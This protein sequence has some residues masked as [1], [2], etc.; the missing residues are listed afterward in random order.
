MRSKC[1]VTGILVGFLFSAFV[2]QAQECTLSKKLD[3]R[4]WLD[5]ISEVQSVCHVRFFYDEET[6]PE[7]TIQIDNDNQS[8]SEVLNRNL[9]PFGLVPSFDGRGNIFLVKDNGMKVSVADGFFDALL[10][11]S[12]ESE[13]E[14][15]V[16]KDEEKDQY[17]RTQKH[18]ITRKVVIGSEKLGAGNRNFTLSGYLKHYEN[19][20]PIVG[21]T[22]LAEELNKGVTSD[23]NGYYELKLKKGKYTIYYNSLESDAQRYQ[24]EG[25]SDG[26]LD[27]MLQESLFEL[28][29]I[30]IY[31][32]VDDNVRGIQMG[33]VRLDAKSLKE[34]PVVLGE[35]DLIKVALLMPGVQTVGEGTAGFNVRGSPADQNLFYISNVPIYNSSH[36]FGFFSAFNTDVV[37]EFTLYKSNI[38]AVYGGRL[39]SIFD[40]KTKHGNM[41]KFSARGGISPITARLMAEG[42]IVKDKLSFLVG[43]RATYS[44]WVLRLLDNPELKD[45]KAFFGDLVLN[46]AYNINQKNRVNAFAYFSQDDATITDQT[47]FGYDNSGMSLSWFHAINRKIDFD[48]SFDFAKYSFTEKNTELPIAAFDQNYS[49]NHSEL[50]LRFNYRPHDKHNVSMGIAGVYYFIDNGDFNPLNEES[51][52]IPK[53]L[54]TERGIEAGLY[55]SDEWIVTPTLTLYGGLRL[56][57][58]GYLGPATVYQYADG[59]P[60]K[61]ENITDTLYYG[62]NELVKSYTGLD[63]RFAATYLLNPDM[64]LKVSYNRLHQYI[65]MLSNTI[66]LAPTDKWKMV[67]YNIR[68]MVGDQ[69]SVGYYT[70]FKKGM[71]EFS[72]EAY[73]K[74]VKNQLEYQDGA[75]LVVNEFPEREVLQGDLNSYGIEFMLKKVT[76]RL[77]GWVNYT[78]SRAIVNV[79]DIYTGEVNNFG[80]SYPANWD[81]PNAFN[82]VLNY[83]L[84]RRLS[85]STDIV[86]ST[87]RP[88]TYP[89]AIY[90]QDGQEILHYSLRN[91]YRL[92]DYFRMDASVVLEGNLKKK[93][94]LHG[95]WIFSVYNLTGRQNA[96]SVY[97]KSEN[98]QINGYKLSIFGTQI[99]SITYDFKLGN[100]ND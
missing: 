47:Q 93:K 70:N 55:I 2:G 68:P 57:A 63:Y 91:E 43:A 7:I 32:D 84:S 23:E 10:T 86:Y 33:Y 62:S 26:R 5:F 78:Y 85:V 56:N 71:F 76:G 58:F 1:I 92:P 74:N 17:L 34:V 28:D 40:I 90:Y 100:I 44:D 83:K 15:V 25:L 6:F 37:D 35:K 54:G 36:F 61:P 66:A 96:Y 53:D 98:G 65:F 97:F 39:S 11:H 88:V 75:D 49:L 89:T 51:L 8:L 42:P 45:S 27:V 16:E 80:L 24:V 73:Y 60:R 81:K 30:E 3:K 12:S 69:I 20:K 95:S 67:D 64:S 21:G 4:S 94:F 48:L 14:T 13:K 99:Y 87:G 38:P 77:N 19:G 18:Y 59:E 46:L 29:E 79:Q 22:I 82:F 72:V 9:K 41:K 52:V 31:S 50:D